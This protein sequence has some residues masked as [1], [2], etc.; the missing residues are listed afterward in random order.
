MVHS[1]KD[2]E[3]VKNAS[4]ILFGKNTKEDLSVIDENVFLDIFSGVPHKKL[5]ES[6]FNECNL[7]E[8]LLDKTAF[9]SSKSEARRLINQNSI[10]INKKKVN[11]E[12]KISEINFINDKYIL[13][14]KGKKNYFL[15]SLII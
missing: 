10:S 3:N 9:F 15:I 13:L 12:F 14:Q 8:D 4:S 6:H 7:V 1:K 11:S 2:L 5:A